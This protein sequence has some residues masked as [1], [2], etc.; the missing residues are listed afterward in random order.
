MVKTRFI[1]GALIEYASDFLGPLP[2]VVIFQ[3]NP[4]TLT[5]TIDIPPRPTGG[6]ARET[7]QAGEPSIE[8]IDFTAKFDAKDS[9]NILAIATGVGPRLAALEKMVHPK[10]PI[11]GLVTK[12][13]DAIGKAVGSGSGGGQPRQIIPRENYP[14]ILFIWG[15]LRVL[16]VVIKSMSITE[17]L[18][19][20]LLNP[21]Q[22]EVKITLAVNEIDDCSND[23]IGKGAFW[24]SNLAKEA[25]AISNLA[26]TAEQVREL[27]PFH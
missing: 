9:G 25:L 23:V 24:Y 5:R 7:T 4:E 1:K 6:T 2:N 8:S 16:P 12:A 11:S 3:F 14:R 22:A 17:L 10:G 13:F 18:Y 20:F 26:N 21:I 27:I 19:D 15:P